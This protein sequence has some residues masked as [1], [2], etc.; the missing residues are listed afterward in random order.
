MDTPSQA[1]NKAAR[2]ILFVCNSRMAFITQDL[3]LL[4]QRY[5]VEEYFVKSDLLNPLAIFGKVRR[6]DL[7]YGW[8]AS[9]HTLL[10]V[11]FARLLG[12][13]SIVVIG[14]Y[15]VANQ[16]EIG[17]GHQRGGLPR[18]VTRLIFRAATTLVTFSRFSYEECVRNAGVDEAKLKMIYCGISLP[19]SPPVA[20]G[21]TNLVLTVGNVS[22]SNLERKGLRLF[23]ETARHLP[24]LPFVMAGNW[25]DEAVTRLKAGSPA[26]LT[27]TGRLSDEAL[28]DYF[29]QARVYVQVSRHEG[30][31]V[32][33]AEAMARGCLP[34]LSRAGSLP[35]VGGDLALYVEDLEPQAVA[36][37][38][39]Q[40]LQTAANDPNLLTRLYQRVRDNF[41]LERRANLL[42]QLIDQNCKTGKRR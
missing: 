1:E 25:V 21:A 39:E 10:P 32:A 20:D 27:F 38:I 16:P 4:R 13:P 3:A 18:L 41:S 23:A 7:V 19:P 31:G 22:Q 8:F 37:T 11:L 42:Y 33:V 17:Y 9:L 6:A 29:R 34:V 14:G 24:R 12:K 35:E 2:R 15:D 26:N 5:E 30:F 28:E 40:A 36:R